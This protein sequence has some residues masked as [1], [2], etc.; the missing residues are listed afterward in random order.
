MKRKKSFILPLTIALVVFGVWRSGAYLYLSGVI[1]NTAPAEVQVLPPLEYFPSIHSKVKAVVLIAHGLNL[2]PTQMGDL[3]DLLQTSDYEV[4]RLA[5]SGHRGNFEELKTITRAIWLDD[6]SKGYK[7]AAKRAVELHVPIYFLGYSHGSVLAIDAA[8]SDPSIRFEKMLLFA[9]A[10]S[11]Y[12]PDWIV[13]WA[14]KLST[15]F[16]FPSSAPR[17]IRANDK[18]TVRAYGA[19]FESIA[20][21]Q[22]SDLTALNVPTKVFIDPDD[23]LVSENG[24][25]KFIE[26]KKL[27]LWSIEELSIKGTEYSFKKHHMIINKPALGKA[28]WARVTE[29]ILLAL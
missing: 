2:S 5:L 25:K 29:K 7:T 26:T 18:L 14:N 24:I 10:V 4:Y 22:N 9:P 23:E 15:D 16:V 11:V 27:S 6:F 1:A 3:S 21:A 28:E 19:L 8:V 12:M 20:T 13:G 17:E